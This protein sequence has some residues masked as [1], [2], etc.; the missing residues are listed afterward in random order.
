MFAGKERYEGR[1]NEAVLI[2][3]ET[4]LGLQNLF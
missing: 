4:L 3:C 2:F 1:Y